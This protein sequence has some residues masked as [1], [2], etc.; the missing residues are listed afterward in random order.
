MEDVIV[1]SGDDKIDDVVVII[2]FVASGMFML[3]IREHKNS[4]NVF[5][6]EQRVTYSE[7]V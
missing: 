1:L 3:I 6:S 7:L 2:V 4:L 5:E